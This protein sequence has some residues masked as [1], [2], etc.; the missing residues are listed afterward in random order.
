[1]SANLLDIPNELQYAI[2]GF[3][4]DLDDAIY[5]SQT[6]RPLRCLYTNH[7]RLINGQIITSSHV[8]EH[9]LCL[10][11]LAEANKA[12]AQLFRQHPH[13][14]VSPENRSPGSK[15]LE[16]INAKWS[17]CTLTD[18]EIDHV[19]ARWRQYG[20]LQDLYRDQSPFRE[21][22]S[23][24]AQFASNLT[25]EARAAIIDPEY[26]WSKSL[27]VVGGEQIRPSQND[28]LWS[29]EV[30]D[31]LYMFLLKK[32]MPLAKL[33]SWIDERLREWPHERWGGPFARL[34]SRPAARGTRSSPI[35]VGL[36]NHLILS[37]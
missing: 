4:P 18:E 10:S 7:M 14:N 23:Y 1:M 12:L 37:T 19:V 32:V 15:Y 3:L 9:D 25:A 2:F 6:C 11:K 30:F 29:L 34:R 5:L 21:F 31:F 22:E 36:S 13:D 20:F 27:I 33:D 24:R 28:K 35:A 26:A 8:H 16:C 17:D